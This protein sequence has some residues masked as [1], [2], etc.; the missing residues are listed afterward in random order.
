MAY[1]LEESQLSGG[2]YT[3]IYDNSFLKYIYHG[4]IA[5]STY[6]LTHI[7]VP[8]FTEGHPPDG[9]IFLEIWNTTSDSYMTPNS[10]LSVS[11]TELPISSLSV[12]QVWYGFSGLSVSVNTGT[13]YCMVFYTDYSSPSAYPNSPMIGKSSTTDPNWNPN[14]FSPNKTIWYRN[15]YDMTQFKAYSGSSD[16]SFSPFPFPRL[17]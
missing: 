5:S 13:K 10:L 6:S 3:Y 2:S 16:R 17:D 7:E 14:G 1:N 9:N 8:F 4:W 15:S 11:S 12:S